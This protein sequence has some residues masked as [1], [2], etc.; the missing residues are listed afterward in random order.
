LLED[1]LHHARADPELPADLED[2]VTIRPK[3]KYPRL[4]RRFDPAMAKFRP[5]R[6]CASET[7]VH[8]LSNNPPLKLGK[9]TQSDTPDAICRSW[10]IAVEGRCGTEAI[11]DIGSG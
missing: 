11:D 1:A 4:H 5:V 9:Y 7:C 6:P 10:R 2:A 8:P 3:F